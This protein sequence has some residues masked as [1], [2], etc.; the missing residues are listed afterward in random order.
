MMAAG[1]GARGILPALALGFACSAQATPGG[2]PIAW[3]ARAAQA[4]RQATFDVAADNGDQSPVPAEVKFNGESLGR[5]NA[6]KRSEV[7]V[8]V[9]AALWN[10]AP[11]A[12]LELHFIEPTSHR[13]Y[14]RP[15]YEW[16]SAWQL[17]RIK[18]DTP[19]PLATA[20]VSVSA[21]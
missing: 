6:T 1:P 15:A 14:R 3:L 5:L 4:A 17:W 21:R 13:S 19:A 20:A 10:R 16:W 7:S 2:D 11:E 9:P 8:L 18:I 12:T